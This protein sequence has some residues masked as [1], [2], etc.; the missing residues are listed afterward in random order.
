METYF[1]KFSFQNICIRTFMR[2]KLPIK[3]V[4]LTFN[5]MGTFSCIIDRI[6]KYMINVHIY[7]NEKK[8]V[9]IIGNLGHA[10]IWT[11]CTKI[12]MQMSKQKFVSILIHMSKQNYTSIL[13]HMS[14]QNYVYASILIQMSKYN[15]ASIL[16]HMSNQNYTSILLHMSKQNYASIIIHMSKLNYTSILTHI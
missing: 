16:I 4:N 15:Y 1:D 14:K 13:I 12:L 9:E 10:A 6:I 2:I 11:T 5:H 8:Y 7:I 3:Q